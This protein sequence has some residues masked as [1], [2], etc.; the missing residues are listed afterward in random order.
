MSLEPSLDVDAF[1]NI[2][3]NIANLGCIMILTE[4]TRAGIVT[5]P[6]LRHKFERHDDDMGLVEI[7][8]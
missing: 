7:K 8:R 5:K 3:A 6:L 4:Y 1:G 2:Q